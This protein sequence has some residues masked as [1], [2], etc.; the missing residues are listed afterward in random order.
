M[1]NVVITCRCFENCCAT[2]EAKNVISTA[3][4]TVVTLS[5]QV[6]NKVVDIKYLQS[7]KSREEIE[8]LVKLL[9]DIV[10]RIQHINHKCKFTMPDLFLLT[11]HTGIS[12]SVCA[13]LS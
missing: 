1:L 9:R 5:G 4:P 10:P 7:C 3:L 11:R 2:M 12:S 6:L 8:K 13:P